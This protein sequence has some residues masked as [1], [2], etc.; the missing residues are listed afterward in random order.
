MSNTHLQSDDE[1]NIA[2]DTNEY[3]NEFDDYEDDSEFVDDHDEDDSEFVD[4]D[5]EDEADNSE[6]EDEESLQSNIKKSDLCRHR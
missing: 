1:E 3:K 5:N 4:D 6:W 2:S